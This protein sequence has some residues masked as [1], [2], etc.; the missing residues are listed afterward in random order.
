MVRAAFLITFNSIRQD[1]LTHA[2][3]CLLVYAERTARDF[4]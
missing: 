1:L 4:A 3:V 2:E